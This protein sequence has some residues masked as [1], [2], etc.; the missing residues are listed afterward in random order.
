MNA[1]EFAAFQKGASA[2]L[3]QLVKTARTLSSGDIPFN[4]S[5]DSDFATALDSANGK[6]LGLINTLVRNAT[7][8][9][10]IRFDNFEDADS[11]ETRWSVVSEVVD[12]LLEKADLC[13]DEYTGTVKRGVMQTTAAGT[14]YKSART[15][16]RT[17]EGR[18]AFNKSLHMAKPQLQF[19]K[20][21][22]PLD[23]SPYKPRL[24]KKPHAVKSLEDSLV[25]AVVD[26]RVKFPHPYTEE[27][28]QYTFP[29]RIRKET[30]P[31]QYKPF[32]STS[33]I[34]VD[35][36]QTLKEMVHQL[37]KAEEIAVDLE[38]HDYR[39]YIGLVCLMQI[40]TR[41]QDWIID[42]LALRDE[43]EILN[44]IFANPRIVKVF[45]GAFMDMI[46]L[47]RDL[48]LYVVGLFD[49]YEAARS[50]GFTGHSLAFLL[51]K[52]INF[53]A[54]KSYQLADW[55]VR[56][57]PKDMLDY[58]RSDTHFLLY[59]YDNMKNELITKSSPEEDKID[60][61]LN[62][63]KDTTLKTYDTEPYDSTNG[64][65][66]RGWL[67]I[68]KHNAIHFTDEQ[69]A[70]FKAVHAWRDRVAREE[71]DNPNFV[72]SKNHLL[73]FARQMPI[74]AAAALSVSNNP[75][76]RAKLA[77]L[78]SI[79]KEAKAHPVPFASIHH[80]LAAVGKYWTPQPK[81]SGN[82]ATE[83][84]VIT[85]MLGAEDAKAKT[86]ESQFWGTTFGGSRWEV[87]DIVDG[88]HDISLALPL[89][90]LTATILEDPSRGI[91][92]D[93]VEQI[94]RAEYIKNREVKN[95]TPD[96]IVVKQAGGGRKR[97]LQEV[98]EDVGG[99]EPSVSA[100]SPD[101]PGALAISGE[102]GAQREVDYEGEAMQLS[103]ADRRAAKK[104]EKK[105]KKEETML[106]RDIA[107]TTEGGFEAFDYAS[108]PSVMN[109]KPKETDGK[110]F[111]GSKKYDDGPKG[112]R[113][114]KREKEGKSVTM[115]A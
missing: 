91:G 36:P 15:D 35:S 81:D 17:P 76:I 60:T 96:I 79:I 101:S 23:F 21:L 94:P 22:S 37:S 44:E 106:K 56:P 115:K 45:H 51:K 38:H 80:L 53:D 57:I 113:A 110:V 49:T 102:E 50:L 11:V 26:G 25:P 67:S 107:S 43:L 9:S 104:A 2:G 93:A 86:E 8:G 87:K 68:L 19:K 20:P 12:F 61:V 64:S 95:E 46:W 40:S 105:R 70:V 13:M 18:K 92:G 10:D 16:K 85:P 71:D 82:N 74:D 73:S 69:F 77:E 32:E 108:A 42:T 55:R 5:L 66:S 78:V 34:W 28:S 84:A 62:H 47:Q 89:P 112:M 24:E 48:N 72:M 59:I 39:T 88:V 1:T 41:E 103:K 52:Y 6:I 109:S 114:R 54:D 90:N 14:N 3:V 111:S 4:K 31:I 100:G 97:K 65:G 30:D 83:E 75:L 33:A 7:D 99:A 29:E 27:I 58:A 63:S 98:A